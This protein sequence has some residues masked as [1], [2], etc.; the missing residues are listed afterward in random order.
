MKTIYEQ[1]KERSLP[2]IKAYHEDLLVHDR[3]AIEQSHPGTPFLH[4]TGN[5]G[6]HIF[7][8]IPPGEYPAKYERVVYLFGTATRDHI[9][10]Q[11]ISCIRH[12]PKV[13]R[14]DLILYYSGNGKV[15]EISQ[16]KAEQIAESYRRS[17]WDSWKGYY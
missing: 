12:M 4:F 2:F 16:E 3:R 17:I 13:N 7:F 11:L 15:Q 9:L 10:D 14:H 5:K 6:T 1:V 8:L